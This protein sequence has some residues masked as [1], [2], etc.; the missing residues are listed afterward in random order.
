MKGAVGITTTSSIAEHISVK[1]R[2]R[3]GSGWRRI[4]TAEVYPDAVQEFC[5]IAEAVLGGLVAGLVEFLPRCTQVPK[6]RL[7]KAGVPIPIRM[8]P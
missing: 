1:P 4:H 7:K 2:K 8:S 6:H 5:K 3:A